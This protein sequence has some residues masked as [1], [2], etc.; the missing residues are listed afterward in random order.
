MSCESCQCTEAVLSLN[1]LTGCFVTEPLLN[2]TKQPSQVEVYRKELRKMMG[3]WVGK[4]VIWR[5][6][7]RPC[8]GKTTESAQPAA[9][10]FSNASL[11]EQ[12]FVFGLQS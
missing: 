9:D 10:F 1:I 12:V 2:L 11:L 3:G 6:T 5:L 4:F 8:A 7:F